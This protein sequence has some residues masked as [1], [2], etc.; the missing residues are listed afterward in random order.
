MAGPATV[1]DMDRLG[2]I[3][4]VS[5]VQVLL[6]RKPRAVLPPRPIVIAAPPPAAEKVAPAETP[7]FPPWAAVVIVLLVLILVVGSVI[8]ATPRLNANAP[9][10][11]PPVR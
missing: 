1:N 6:T 7:K 4:N 10:Y 2:L 8:A 5:S 11:A 3:D 9:K